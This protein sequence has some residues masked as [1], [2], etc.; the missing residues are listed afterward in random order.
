[1]STPV[2]MLA[3]ALVFMAIEGL[4]GQEVLPAFRSANVPEERVASLRQTLPCR[5]EALEQSLNR[6]KK[7]LNE[8]FGTAV[9]TLQRERVAKRYEIA[10]RLVSCIKDDLARGDVS[11]LCF[12]EIEVADLE[13][14]LAY[15]AAER[16]AWKTFPENPE[17]KP[18]MVR[19]EDFGA[20]GD[21][22]A[23]DAPAF[24]AAIAA[25]KKLDGAPSMLCIPAGTFLLASPDPLTPDE[26]QTN[27]VFPALTNCIVTGVSP[28]RT[29][30][31]FGI[32]DARGICVRDGYNSVF[33]NFEIRWR[34]TPFF[35][36]EILG[37]NRKE[38]WID[39]AHDEGT[40]SPVDSRWLAQ[41]HPLGL[42]T[43]RKD[44]TFIK[45]T[46]LFW[47]RRAQTNGDGSYRLFFDAERPGWKDGQAPIKGAKA[48]LPDRLSGFE[49][50]GLVDSH[51]CTVESVW[52]R[53][54]REAFLQPG[55]CY[56]CSAVRCR[57]FPAEGRS[58][59]TNAD[60]FFNSRG[61][62]ISDCE[63]TN[64]GDDGCNSHMRG[65]DIVKADGRTLL[66][67][68]LGLPLRIGELCQIV[69]STTGE[70]LANLHV[71][72]TGTAEW[73]GK[74]WRRIDFVEEIPP[75]VHTYESTGRGDITAEERRQITLGL[76]KLDRP[77]DILFAPCSLGV[78]YVA[79]NN[80]FRN[81]R[82]TAMVV[83]CPNAIIEGNRAEGMQNGI[84]VG[85]LL[86][87]NE[88]PAPYNVVLRNN[89]LKD[90]YH[91]I[92]TSYTMNNGATPGTRPIRHLLL[93]GNKITGCTYESVDLSMADNPVVRNAPDSG[94]DAK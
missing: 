59:S 14:F 63:F 15:F 53:N 25:V 28:E 41:T 61:S 3:L 87:W 11:S 91:G 62:W 78:G 68:G 46:L 52:I 21:G 27:L 32:Y 57:I 58:F 84:V 67:K 47:P 51:L 12:A 92:I 17:V 43:Y 79:R 50:F 19:L 24:R 26:R 82:N 88:G 90:N 56:Q 48:V 20:V 77:P 37:Y 29:F 38:G 86:Q 34:E 69:E 89:V 54:S 36:G 6:E 1:M 2:K 31:R 7:A 5:L 33:R 49:A 80:V 35:E 74:K 9:G 55:R 4:F 39:V 13:A 76:L 75:G 10:R 60:G 73:C 93:E 81:N 64:M 66:C 16:E 85:A 22:V 70:Y 40:L 45:T 71:A 42:H 72:S 18:V 23:D 8:V 83:Q 94:P 30:M 44:G 65:G